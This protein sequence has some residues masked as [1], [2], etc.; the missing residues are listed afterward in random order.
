M[1]FPL[2]CPACGKSAHGRRLCYEMK[3]GLWAIVKAG[4][5]LKNGHARSHQWARAALG[6]EDK[7]QIDNT[8]HV[9]DPDGDVNTY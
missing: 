9:Y 4:N 8:R 2:N 1:T 3:E 7:K 6:L 5:D